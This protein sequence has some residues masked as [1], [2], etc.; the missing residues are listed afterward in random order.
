MNISSFFLKKIIDYYNKIIIFLDVTGIIAREAKYYPLLKKT[1]T[2][3]VC[4]KNYP[5][6][7]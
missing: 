1:L 3:K 4:K 7:I 6:P 5:S 2:E